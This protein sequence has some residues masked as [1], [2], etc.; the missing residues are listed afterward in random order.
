MRIPESVVRVKVISNGIENSVP[1]Q[2]S[3]RGKKSVEAFYSLPGLGNWRPQGDSYA[4]LSILFDLGLP[5]SLIANV[6]SADKIRSQLAKSIL[7]GSTIQPSQMS[8][9][10]C[11]A[12]LSYLGYRPVFVKENWHRTPDLRIEEFDGHCIDIEVTRADARHIHKNVQSALRDLIGILRA[13][14][15]GFHLLVLLADARVDISSAEVLEK[16]LQLTPGETA[17]VPMNWYI[18]AYPLAERDFV[19]SGAAESADSPD[20]WPRSGPKAFAISALVSATQSP[21]VRIGSL[22][23]DAVYINP[24]KNK[25]E[26][27]QKEI[28]NC[29]VVALDAGN[30]PGYEKKIQSELENYFSQWP[31]VSGVLAFQYLPWAGYKN[32]Q[33]DIVFYKNDSSRYPTP[34]GF[35]NTALGEKQKIIF[36]IT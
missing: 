19:V 6:A 24:V 36:S 28:G 7:N 3:D 16:V 33:W 31:H 10:S 17:E 1:L 27:P 5:L 9:I 29:Y 25:A 22:Y 15:F 12:I 18:K 30:L 34:N 11:C 23:P 35:L 20:W 8:E 4:E 13:G 14:D 26:R 2:L 21:Y 32:K